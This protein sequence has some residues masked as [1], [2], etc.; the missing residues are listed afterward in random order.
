MR[1]VMT[2]PIVGVMLK[3]CV[4]V[5]GSRSLSCIRK[6]TERTVSNCITHASLVYPQELSSG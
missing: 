1:P 2:H 3:R 5:E 4:M 6:I